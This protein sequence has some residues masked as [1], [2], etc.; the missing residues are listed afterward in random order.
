MP[1][2]SPDGFPYPLPADSLIDYPALGLALATR[3]EPI[4]PWTPITLWGDDWLPLAGAGSP[5]QPVFMVDHSHIVHLRGLVTKT[6]PPATQGTNR[7]LLSLPLTL[8]AQAQDYFPAVTFDGTSA[9]GSL[10]VNS[11]LVR[12]ELYFAAAPGGL[13]WGPGGS[14]WLSLAGIH[15]QL[16]GASA[17]PAERIEGGP[18]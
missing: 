14:A 10:I 3:L 11:Q 1:A 7:P 13:P 5:N 16:T 15:W 4:T 12:P 8:L 18:S 2:T 6:T 9:P 17:K